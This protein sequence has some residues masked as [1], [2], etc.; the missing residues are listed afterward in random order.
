MR[1]LY[2]QYVRGF[3]SPGEA[4]PEFSVQG[5]EIAYVFPS[6]DSLACVAVSVNLQRF[7]AIRGSLAT[8]FPDVINGH[9]ALA[10]R[11][12]QAVP[13]SRVLGCGPERSYV[14]RPAGPGWALVG[15]A[16][17]HQD[18]WSGQGIDFAT[19]HAT[20]LAAAVLDAGA[21]PDAERE[22]MDRY[23]AR[24]DEHGLPGYRETTEFAA[25]ISRLVG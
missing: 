2:Y 16:S 22:W 4:G 19:T 23:S 1:A 6:D 15:D 11:F 8:S 24:R 5:D 20:F 17:M 21:G 18:P 13:A 7:R 25:D 14:R 3:P 12:A 9:P 10:E